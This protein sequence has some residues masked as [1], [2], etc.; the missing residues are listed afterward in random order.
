MPEEKQMMKNSVQLIDYLLVDQVHGY[1]VLLELCFVF[2]KD[3]LFE[4]ILHRV[5]H[6]HEQHF[7][8]KFVLFNNKRKIDFIPYEKP[9]HFHVI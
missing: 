3:L 4:I 6:K 1:I 8:L 2:Q 9:K 5:D 7:L